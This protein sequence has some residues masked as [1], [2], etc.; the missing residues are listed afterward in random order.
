MIVKIIDGNNDNEMLKEIVEKIGNEKY[1]EIEKEVNKFCDDCKIDSAISLV[2]CYG[3]DWRDKAM[4][5]VYD[6]IQDFNEAPKY[7][8]VLFKEIVKK[9]KNR[10]EIAK[11]K[12]GINLY[13]KKA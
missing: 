4:Q 11:G 5:S 1:L 2:G 12:G 10:F 6:A 3:K 8:G 13:Y 7:A 9:H